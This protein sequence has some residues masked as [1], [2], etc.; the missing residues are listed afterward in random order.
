MKLTEFSERLNNKFTLIEMNEIYPQV[1]KYGV[2][3]EFILSYNQGI[4]LHMSHPEA[5]NYA[6]RLCVDCL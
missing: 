2:F 3:E 5:I 4:N 6:L 1:S